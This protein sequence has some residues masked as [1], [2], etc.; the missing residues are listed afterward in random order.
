[1]SAF[2][3]TH[4]PLFSERTSYMK[5][6]LSQSMAQLGHLTLKKKSAIF[7]VLAFNKTMSHTLNSKAG[8][9]LLDTE[10]STFPDTKATLYN[11]QILYH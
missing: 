11:N 2:Y 3:T 7:S 1:M 10:N 6:I 5:Y 9:I 4:G 8:I